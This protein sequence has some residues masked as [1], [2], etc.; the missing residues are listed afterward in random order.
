VFAFDFSCRIFYPTDHGQN[1]L[2]DRIGRGISFVDIDGLCCLVGGGGRNENNFHGFST[3]E[4][5]PIGIVEFCFIHL[6]LIIFMGTEQRMLCT[7]KFEDFA[8][9]FSIQE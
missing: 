1:G 8:F 2:L 3:D 5:R 7:E 6:S 9:V 4:K